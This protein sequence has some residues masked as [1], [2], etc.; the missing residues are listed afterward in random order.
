MEVVYTALTKL[1]KQYTTYNGTS[2]IRVL[3]NV[4]PYVKHD[5]NTLLFDIEDCL[6]KNNIKFEK[7]IIRFFS[8]YPSFLIY[9]DNQNIGI[10]AFNFALTI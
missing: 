9:K 10:V 5:L 7:K 4:E 3:Y 2:T 6:N 1:P 8:E